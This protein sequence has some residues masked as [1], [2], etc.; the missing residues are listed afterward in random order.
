MVFD[1]RV[2]GPTHRLRGLL[3]VVATRSD[4]PPPTVEIVEV[5][6]SDHHLL[7]WTVPTARQLLSS[8]S[9]VER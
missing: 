4:R 6:L 8:A 2:T 1:L 7:Q 9:I 5:E 3:D